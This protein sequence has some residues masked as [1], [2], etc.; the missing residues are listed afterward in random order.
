MFKTAFLAAALLATAFVHADDT[1]TASSD[2]SADGAP[3]PKFAQLQKRALA[4]IDRA[5][6]N[7]EDARDCVASATD[8][9][10]LKACKP[11]QGSKGK[12]D[13]GADDSAK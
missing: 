3:N 2:K 12:S 1:T 4:R 7:L 11:E 13:S 8:I 6:A 5:I 10:S 9:A